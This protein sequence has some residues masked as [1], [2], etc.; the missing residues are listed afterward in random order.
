MKWPLGYFITWTTYGTW[1]HGD[2]RGS[3]DRNGDFVPADP[4][5]REAA[6][7]I[8]VDDP[9]ILSTEQ[10]AAVDALLVDACARR[11]WVLHARNVRTTH[12]HVVVSAAVDGEIVRKKLKALAS[13]EL[14]EQAGLP[15]DMGK[16]GAKKWW[17]EKGNIEEVETERQ[18]AATVVYV[19]EMQ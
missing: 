5:R 16:N 2:E 14:S 7:A 6:E 4:A 8:M 12:V 19:V 10:R 9:V 3:F 15:V 1:L 13:K 18:L 11:D 17:T